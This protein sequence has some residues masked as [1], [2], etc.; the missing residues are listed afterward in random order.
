MLKL[1]PIDPLSGPQLSAKTQKFL[2]TFHNP[3]GNKT[4]IF[5]EKETSNS[6]VAWRYFLL[7]EVL[8]CQVNTLCSLEVFAAEA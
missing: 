4:E 3:V 7:T 8:S 1:D 6:F 5:A 2:S